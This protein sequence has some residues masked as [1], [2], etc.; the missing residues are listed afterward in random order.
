MTKNPSVFKL[1]A[2]VNECVHSMIL[3][4]LEMLVVQ[5]IWNLIV[6]RFQDDVMKAM[7]LHNVNR[8]SGTFCY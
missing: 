6:N 1:H 7:Q 2:S 3:N 8:K 5:D 4:G